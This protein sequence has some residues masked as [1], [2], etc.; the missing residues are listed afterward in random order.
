MTG[1]VA[2]LMS[3]RTIKAVAREPC[4]SSAA[5]AQAA[6]QTRKETN[7]NDAIR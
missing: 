1:T 5:I 2:D 7:E 4:A 6:E 3:G